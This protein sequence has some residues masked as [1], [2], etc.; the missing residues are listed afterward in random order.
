MTSASPWRS[1]CPI[2]ILLEIV[3]DRWSFLI[4]R[5]LMLKSR[6]LFGELLDGGE[7]IATNI[8]ADR[9]HRLEKH[10]LIESHP[11]PCDR[12]RKVYRLTERGIELAPLLYEM[13]L[14]AARNE[15]T[16]APPAEIASM[17][18]D[19][20]AYL[21]AIRQSWAGSNIKSTPQ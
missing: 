9:L 6:H 17:K 12:R 15:D 20:D 2:N 10:R 16:A 19:R 18:K 7:C 3:G 14:W 1:A 5:D 8:L 13:I 21:A 4:I 11:D